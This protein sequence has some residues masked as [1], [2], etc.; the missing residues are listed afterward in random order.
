[1]GRSGARTGFKV[2]SINTTIRN[3]KRNADFLK[4]FK[5]Y[6]KLVMD[7]I[8]TYKYFFYLVQNGIYTF[9]NIPISVKEK[10][11]LGIELSDDEVIDAIEKNPQ[12]TGLHGRVMTQLRALKDQGFLRFEKAA[13][14]QNKITITKLGHEIIDNEIDGTITYTK[15]MIGLHA[16]NPARSSMLNESVPF[17]NTLFVIN[18]VNKEWR[19]MGHE[20]KGILR[21]EFGAFVLSMKDCDY[22]RAANDIIEYRKRNRYKINEKDIINHLN[23]NDIL[24]LKM[25]SVIAD[26]PDDVFRKFE[27][28]GLLVARGQFGYRYI[29]F[30]KYNME[31]VKIILEDYKNYSFKHFT[32]EDDYYFYLENIK[33]PWEKDELIRRKVI[34]SKCD[35]LGLKFDEKLDLTS[36]EQMLD[37]MFYRKALD[38][39]IKDIELELIKQE[40]KILAGTS[41][42]ET[43]FGDLGEPLRLE[44]LLALL[45]G[46]IYGTSKLVSNIIYAENGKPLHYAPAGKSDIILYDEKG[47]YILEPTMQKGRNQQL[48]NETTNIV[49]HVEIEKEKSGLDF[50]VLMIAPVI[51]IDVTRFFKYMVVSEDAKIIPASIERSTQLF[52]DNSQIESLNRDFDNLVEHMKETDLKVF[53]DEMNAYR[54]P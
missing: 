20:P 17:L 54:M 45:L 7:N 42:A 25:N 34:E 4:L 32:T 3:P 44:Y 41:D 51:H 23:K 5:K 39:A 38:N 18:E 13:R 26:Y 49:R 22:K 12:A 28:T 16:K 43:K 48:N 24:E 10:L 47:S 1:M 31:K 8:N 30:S 52:I 2:Y 9:T 36:Q 6:D 11:E 37:Q 33:I 21:H 29:D 15:A 19:N 50:R 40:L 46:K 27:M 14:G 35:V 53:V